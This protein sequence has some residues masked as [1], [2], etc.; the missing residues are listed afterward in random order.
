MLA[1]AN[2]MA[3]LERREDEEGTVIWKFWRITAHEGPLTKPGHH[4][5]KG[6]S[7]NVMVEW[8]NGEVTVEPLCIIAKDDPVTC[9]MYVQDHGLL[10]TDGWR[11]RFKG[12]ERRQ[13]KLFWMMANQ[14][15]LHSFLTA[16]QYKYGYEIARNY[17]HALTLDALNGNTKW[18]DCTALE[19][20][21]LYD[22]AT[23]EDY[24]SNDEVKP[25][26]G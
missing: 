24:G 19:M 21:Q 16:P 4:N 20:N 8:E 11:K 15:K 26:S 5:W 2:I 9:A 10:E 17:P 7:Y 25:P 6:S 14:A 13:K 1:Y 3:H 18:R 12:I 22:Y 23:F